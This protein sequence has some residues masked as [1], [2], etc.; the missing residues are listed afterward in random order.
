MHRLC[1]APRDAAYFAETAKIGRGHVKVGLPQRYVFTAIALI[2]V[3]LDRIV[4]TAWPSR[5]SR[6]SSSAI[7][8][9]QYRLHEYDLTAKDRKPAV[10][11]RSVAASSVHTIV[12][13]D[14]PTDRDRP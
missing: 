1:T 14:H 6:A 11:E 8:T 7:R 2:R 9:I 4:D 12:D 3:E 13:N 10:Q 5:F